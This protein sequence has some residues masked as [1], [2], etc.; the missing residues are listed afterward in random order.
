MPTNDCPLPSTPKCNLHA[1]HGEPGEEAQQ[2]PIVTPHDPPT[3]RGISRGRHVASPAARAS[4]VDGHSPK[5]R[6]RKARPPP[7]PKQFKKQDLTE[8]SSCLSKGSGTDTY[9]WGQNQVGSV[10]R[11]IDVH[12]KAMC[13]KIAKRDR[14]WDGHCPIPY[15]YPTSLQKLFGGRES[16]LQ[17]LTVTTVL[18][19]D[20]PGT[21]SVPAP[22]TIP[23]TAAAK[24]H[25]TGQ[26]ETPKH[27]PSTDDDGGQI[28]QIP[29][30]DQNESRPT[31]RKRLSKGDQQGGDVKRARETL[32][33]TTR[34]NSA[35]G[36]TT[37]ANS[38][39][40]TTSAS[41]PMDIGSPS[42]LA[43]GTP[44]TPIRNQNPRGGNLK[45]DRNPFD[46]Y[47]HNQDSK[48][49]G[50]GSMRGV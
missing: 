49:D 50:D 40:E 13:V 30:Q 24:H 1:E 35:P 17:E 25:N 46:S 15:E 10:P 37:R 45:A 27:I 16:F 31:N 38:N 20:V 18:V 34:R 44:G 3:D 41:Q 47:F 8:F 14:Q 43:L 21:A 5:S 22:P 29:R 2:G 4:R 26:L 6:S 39:N 12:W 48:K 33:L 9:N 23:T 36:L 42:P 28:E 32:L 7:P 19:P 11:D